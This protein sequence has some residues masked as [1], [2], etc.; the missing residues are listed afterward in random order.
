MTTINNLSRRSNVDRFCSKRHGQY[1]HHIMLF[2][3]I[4]AFAEKIAPQS[5][6]VD[7]GCGNKPYLYL[8]EG[9]NYLGIDIDTANE[10]ADIHGSAY[11]LPIESNSCEYVNNKNTVLHGVKLNTHQQC[12]AI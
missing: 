12:Y 11:D 9:H 10:Y 5:T 7:I 4:K 6:I 2:R 1:L 3:G 8:F